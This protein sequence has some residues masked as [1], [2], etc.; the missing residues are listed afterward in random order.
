M[1]EID[2]FVVGGTEKKINKQPLSGS[3]F[4]SSNNVTF[5]PSQNLDL[6]CLT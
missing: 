3:L 4:L 1:A 6:C 5:T 2:E